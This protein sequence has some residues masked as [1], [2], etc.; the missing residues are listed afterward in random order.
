MWRVRDFT[1][2]R[3]TKTVNGLLLRGTFYTLPPFPTRFSANQEVGVAYDSLGEYFRSQRRWVGGAWK[4][5]EF[6]F[7][8]DSEKKNSGRLFGGIHKV[9]NSE[10]FGNLKVFRGL[11][12]V[13]VCKLQVIQGFPKKDFEFWKGLED[14]DHLKT[15]EFRTT[16]FWRREQRLKTP[17]AIVGLKFIFYIGFWSRFSSPK[18][19]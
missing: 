8:E 1:R 14:S 7:S 10:T 3:K 19:H 6:V 15:Q 11:S 5:H 2:F 17:F 12:I 9:Q 4:W 13:E 16:K 18:D